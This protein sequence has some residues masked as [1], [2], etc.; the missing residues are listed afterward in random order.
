MKKL[1]ILMLPLILIFSCKKDKDS[2]C[3]TDT[4]S[5]SGSYKITAMT[6]KESPSS[7]EEDYFTLVFPDACERDD[8]MTFQTNG[9]YQSTDV[10]IVCSPAGGDNGT[11][12]LSASTM[13]IDGDPVTIE[14]FNCKTLILVNSDTQT[15][16]DKFRITLT[17]Q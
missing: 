8:V 10:G 1:T 4:A 9:T 17:K 7:P 13:T 3:V 11:W 5:I 2:S 14:S 15:Q 6:Y 12:S 16:G